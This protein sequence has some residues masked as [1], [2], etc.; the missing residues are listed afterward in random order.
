MG[1]VRQTRG[2]THNWGSNV[3][4]CNENNV[5]H[6]CLST[7][8]YHETVFSLT[9]QWGYGKSCEALVA[10]LYIT[11]YWA[12]YYHVETLQTLDACSIHHAH[13]IAHGH[14]AVTYKWHGTNQIGTNVINPQCMYL[15]YVSITELDDTIDIIYILYYGTYTSLS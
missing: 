15:F 6:H 4:H 8:Y 7:L 1:T 13:T 2:W 5:W 14:M 12:I 10:I 3:G 11:V 9:Q